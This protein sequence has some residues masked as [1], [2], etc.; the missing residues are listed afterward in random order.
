MF[1]LSWGLTI[2]AP[3]VRYRISLHVN[4]EDAEGK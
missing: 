2:V 4:V 1:V 3:E